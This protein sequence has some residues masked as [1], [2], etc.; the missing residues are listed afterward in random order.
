MYWKRTHQVYVSVK[1]SPTPNGSPSQLVS[2]LETSESSLLLPFSL[3]PYKW[4]TSKC[5]WYSLP[6]SS[7]SFRRDR[8]GSIL[9]PVSWSRSLKAHPWN[10]TMFH[11]NI[12][13]SCHVLVS[14]PRMA[15]TLLYWYVQVSMKFKETCHLSLAPTYPSFPCLWALPSSI[16]SKHPN[17]MKVLS[18]KFYFSSILH[19]PLL[20]PDLSKGVSFGSSSQLLSYFSETGFMS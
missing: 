12:K 13:A 10:A 20:C 5:Y 17:L 14:E 8:I 18:L 7:Q 16:Y 3:I 2:R 9:P 6:N 15:P 4:Y 1:L 19:Q 11:P